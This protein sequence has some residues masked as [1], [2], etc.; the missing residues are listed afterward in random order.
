[1]D[2]F[3]TYTRSD[4]LPVEHRCGC[5]SQ[6]TPHHGCV[7][8]PPATWAEVEVDRGPVSG[9]LGYGHHLGRGCLCLDPPL[10][11]PALTCSLGALPWRQQQWGSVP[12][13]ANAQARLSGHR[14]PSFRWGS[15]LPPGPR[16]AGCRQSDWALG[17]KSIFLLSFLLVQEKCW[18]LRD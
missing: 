8:L 3:K 10:P 15:G 5:S 13:C 11:K 2:V 18:E 12:V 1:M 16:L 9:A 7:Y 4:L 14:L 6:G 17:N